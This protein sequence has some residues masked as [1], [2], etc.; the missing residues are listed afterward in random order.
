MFEAKTR[1]VLNAFVY[2]ENVVPTPKQM[3]SIM[4]Q[5]E[6]D[7][8]SVFPTNIIENTLI[9]PKTRFA[10]RSSNNEW[11]IVFS[12][13][14]FTVNQNAELSQIA[15]L[16]S[17]EEFC[18]I[19]RSIL[20]AG[21]E[22]FDV[23]AH[24]FALEQSGYLPVQTK[25]QMSD[26]G[27]K[28]LHQPQDFRDL[29][30]IEWD[31]RVCNRRDRSFATHSEP[32]NHILT[33]KK[34][35]QY[36]VTYDAQKSQIVEQAEAADRVLVQLEINTIPEKPIPRFTA[37][38]LDSFVEGGLQWQSELESEMQQILEG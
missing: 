28:L 38:D 16:G 18:Q 3:A 23:A 19:A 12:G 6:I 26:L 20:H 29:D 8:N 5:I 22:V 7:G 34:N 25:Q 11:Q 9:G 27:H 13:G 2:A 17:F 32:M 35:I 1:H 15:T 36:A 37:Q 33:I 10:L 21:L 4:S 30:L 14:L 24:R 31:W